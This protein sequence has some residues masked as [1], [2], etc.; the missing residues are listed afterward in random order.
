MCLSLILLTDCFRLSI[1]FQTSLT[2]RH[3]GC[4]TPNIFISDSQTIT[5]EIKKIDVDL[6]KACKWTSIALITFLN[7]SFSA[8]VNWL[9]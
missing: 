7:L 8:G 4:D 9:E 5:F 2:N 3:N 1:H 6:S